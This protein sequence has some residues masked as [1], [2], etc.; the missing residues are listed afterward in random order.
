MKEV[1]NPEKLKELNA[2]FGNKDS[3]EI[4]GGVEITDPNK[5][6]ELN[7]II[8]DDSY[9]GKFKKSYRSYKRFFYRY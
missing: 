7:K 3:D 1:T 8:E 5:L 2:L 6:A 4:I 9:I